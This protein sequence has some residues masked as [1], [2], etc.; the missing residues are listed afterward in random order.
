METILLE[1]R[2]VI[3]DVITLKD[4]N[5]ITKDTKLYYELGYKIDARLGV[6]NGNWVRT[7]YFKEI[8]NPLNF[9]SEDTHMLR[10]EYLKHHNFKI[11]L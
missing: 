2:E 7:G 9:C 1:N 8:E 6:D 5:Q 11:K 3:Q 4:I 10:P